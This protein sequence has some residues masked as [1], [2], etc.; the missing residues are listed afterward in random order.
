MTKKNK[1][2]INSLANLFYRLHG[3]QQDFDYDF[4]TARHPQE[5]LMFKMAEVSK[6]FWEFRIKKENEVT[7]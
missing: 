2:E 5:K 6:Q 3:Y 1:K 7:K 4:S